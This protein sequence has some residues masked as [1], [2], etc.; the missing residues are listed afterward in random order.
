MH[1]CIRDIGYVLFYYRTSNK[2]LIVQEM[3]CYL[4]GKPRDYALIENVAM[5]TRKSEKSFDGES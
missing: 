2:V 1:M 5:E 4:Y 3:R